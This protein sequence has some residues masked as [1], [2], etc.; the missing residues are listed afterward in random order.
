[1]A[2]FTYSQKPPYLKPCLFKKNCPTTLTLTSVI[3]L[4][5]SETHAWERPDQLLLVTSDLFWQISFKRWFD[6]MARYRQG[7]MQVK[8][9]TL[10]HALISFSLP[11]SWPQ[12]IPGRRSL[13]F[14]CAPL[15]LTQR[16]FSSLLGFTFMFSQLTCISTILFFFFNKGKAQR[17][18]SNGSDLLIMGFVENRNWS[19]KGGDLICSG[20]SAVQSGRA[21]GLG[22]L[23][24]KR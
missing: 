15:A 17:D 4:C 9:E 5:G 10:G 18:F 21:R 11:Q 22:S 8:G 12:G 3:D 6:K 7:R 24:Q 14:S 16:G 20:S 1:M 19:S 13:L 23:H 2:H